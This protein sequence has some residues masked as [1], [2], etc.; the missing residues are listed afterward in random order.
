M[1]KRALTAISLLWITSAQAVDLGGLLNSTIEKKL[2]PLTDANS[3]IGSNNI[4]KSIS[5]VI[6][7]YSNTGI[8]VQGAN[9]DQVVFYSTATCGYC[10]AA[11][12]YMQNQGIPYLEKDIGRDP[13]ARAELKT[14][15]DRGGVPVLLMGKYK[16]VGFEETRFNQTYAKFQADLKSQTP[17]GNPPS[18][19]N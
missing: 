2:K 3:A 14:V 4:V 17:Q 7:G 10:A 18:A 15:D 5:E 6:T 1:L 11:R 8:R 19:A 9:P 16:L 13:A 12:R